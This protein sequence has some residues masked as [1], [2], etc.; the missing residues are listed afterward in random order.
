MRSVQVHDLED[1]LRDGVGIGAAVPARS[2]NVLRTA[3]HNIAVHVWVGGAIEGTNVMK[4]WRPVGPVG[5]EK[6]VE[7]RCGTVQQ[8]GLG[9]EVEVGVCGFGVLVAVELVLG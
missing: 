9:S 7:E 2:R 8:D 4:T 1:G 5:R 3:E 6:L